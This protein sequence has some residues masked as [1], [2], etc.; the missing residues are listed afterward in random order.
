MGLLYRDSTQKVIQD[1]PFTLGLAGG[2]PRAVVRIPIRRPA[3]P[4]VPPSPVVRA[5]PSKSQG[6]GMALDDF[7]S[8]IPIEKAQKGNSAFKK[9]SNKY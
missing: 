3:V 5:L 2:A 6:A 7:L 8:G 9:S 4:V 1:H